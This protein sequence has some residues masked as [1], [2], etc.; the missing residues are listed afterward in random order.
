MEPDPKTFDRMARSCRL[1]IK[2][3]HQSIILAMVNP[4]SPLLVVV[5]PPT[6]S[7]SYGTGRPFSIFGRLIGAIAQFSLYVAVKLISNENGPK[8]YRKVILHIEKIEV[9][10]FWPFFKLLNKQGNQDAPL[11]FMRT[12]TVILPRLFE[13]KIQRLFQGIKPIQW[14]SCCAGR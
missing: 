13:R 5:S 9:F 2:P 12:E 8:R 14:Y 11:S 3:R 6:D 10:I 4:C 1:T 7:V